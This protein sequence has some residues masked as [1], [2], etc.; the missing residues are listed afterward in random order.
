MFLGDIMKKILGI[1]IVCLTLLLCGCSKDNNIKEISYKEFKEKIDNKESFPV[2]IGKE[3]CSYCISY[4]PT[5]EA[6]VKENNITLYYIDYSKLKDKELI[7]FSSILKIDG[8]PTVAFITD[9]EE[10]TTLNRIEGQ[11][12]KEK[13]IRKFKSNG[14]IK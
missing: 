5:L 3:N 1:F 10:E 8:T 4:K 6:V 7:E 2:Y 13:T 12:S 11:A 14:Y 9:G